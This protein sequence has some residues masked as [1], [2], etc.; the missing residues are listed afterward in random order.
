MQYIKICKSTVSVTGDLF[1]QHR[2]TGPDKSGQQREEIPG[3]IQARPAV[4]KADQADPGHGSYESEKEGEAEL[5]LF[6]GDKFRKYCCEERG[7]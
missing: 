2:V 1:C 5:L 7:C 3:R 6:P 4:R